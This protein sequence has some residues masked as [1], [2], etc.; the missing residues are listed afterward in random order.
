MHY[1]NIASPA[2]WDSKRLTW[3]DLD[4]DVIRDASTGSLFIDDEDE[5]ESHIERFA[6]PEK[7]V[8]RCRAELH[9]IHEAM[10]RRMGI[11][12]DEIFAWRLGRSLPAE[13]LVPGFA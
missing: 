1:V 2:A 11:F 4:L 13:L 10:F 5:F 9:R 7:L 12:G 3:A 6:Y 8:D